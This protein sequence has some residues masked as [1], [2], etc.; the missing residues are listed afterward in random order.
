MYGNSWNLLSRFKVNIT[1][2]LCFR[3]I[4]IML[5]CF[6]NRC[7]DIRNCNVTDAGIYT[8]C[9]GATDVEYNRLEEQSWTV[10]SFRKLFTKTLVRGAADD[11]EEDE[12][13]RA[14]CGQCK[15]LREFH[16]QCPKITQKGLQIAL[17]NLPHLQ[18]LDHENLFE[19]LTEFHQ[20]NQQPLPQYSLV[21]LKLGPVM[22]EYRK[23]SL[24]LVAS[25]CPSVTKVDLG[26]TANHITDEELLGLFELKTLH[27]LSIKYL[28]IDNSITFDGGLVP[29]FKA[30]GSSLQTL[31]ISSSLL[32]VDLSLLMELCPNLRILELNTGFRQTDNS[33]RTKTGFKQLEVL[34]ISINNSDQFPVPSEN[35]I[36]LLPASLTSLHIDSC[37]TLTDSILQQVFEIHS[38]P[39]L[40]ELEFVNCESISKKSIDL[41]MNETNA[42]E[43]MLLFGCNVTK[44]NVAEWQNMAGQNNWNLM[45]DFTN[46]YYR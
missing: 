39:N 17:K 41:F 37:S 5:F 14:Q 33:E 7:L 43:Q 36:G 8:L 25:I 18:I 21:D 2:R 20:N 1:L 6:K 24:K 27:E 3:S 16:I 29:L 23:G 9:G 44:E 19:A 11:T 12:R 22:S 31:S 45:I 32:V 42:L 40:R 13:M 34:K 26:Q 10:K 30:H 46:Y 38:F 4:T 15:S 35:F 28:Y